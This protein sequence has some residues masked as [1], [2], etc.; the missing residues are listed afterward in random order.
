MKLFD[1]YNKLAYGNLNKESLEY[2]NKP[3]N[4]FT[5]TF[6]EFSTNEFPDLKETEK[7]IF[8]II[9]F[10]GKSQKT[11]CWDNYQKFMNTCDEDIRL[12]LKIELK[13]LGIPYTKDYGDY[14]ENIQESLGVLIMRLKQHYNRARP[15]QVAYYTNQNLHPFFTAS[16]NTPAYPS[17]HAAQG[18]FLCNIVAYHYPEKKEKLMKLSH[19]IA[20]SRIAMGLHYPSDNKFGFEIADALSKNPNVIKKYFKL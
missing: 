5:E 10:M 20:N 7:E 3:N 16:G 15:Y 14:L 11:K 6:S 8:Q 2:V 17:G 19:K 9:E 12:A 4:L 13:R 1:I 18:R